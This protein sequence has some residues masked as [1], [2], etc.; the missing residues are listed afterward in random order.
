MFYKSFFIL[1]A[2]LRKVIVSFVTCVSPSARKKSVPTK[3]IFIKLD[4]LVFLEN[5]PRNFKFRYNVT[6]ITGTLRDDRY[7]FMIISH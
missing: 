7:T 3:W 4:T 1:F 5:L 2:K 6:R